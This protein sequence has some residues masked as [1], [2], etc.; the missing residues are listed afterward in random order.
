M[1]WLQVQLGIILG[2]LASLYWGFSSLWTIPLAVSAFGVLLE[3]EYDIETY[4]Y[5]RNN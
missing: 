5:Y 3:I 1:T 4:F 2:G